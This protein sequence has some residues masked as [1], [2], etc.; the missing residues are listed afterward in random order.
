M[1]VTGYYG[2]AL[3]NAFVY[4]INCGIVF[5]YLFK[6]SKV[7]NIRSCYSL[8]RETNGQ[9][10]PR[11]N[12]VMRNHVRERPKNVL[13]TALPSIILVIMFLFV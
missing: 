11:S 6:S 12:I 13:G 5:K 7:L 1:H 3:R 9:N 2:C 4:A 10:V 8:K